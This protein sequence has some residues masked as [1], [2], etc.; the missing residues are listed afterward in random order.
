MKYT[1]TTSDACRFLDR[2]KMNKSRDCLTFFHSPPPPPYIVHRTWHP[3]AGPSHSPAA[4]SDSS[5]RLWD[6]STNRGGG[7]ESEP[8]VIKHYTGHQK[9][10]VCVALNDSNE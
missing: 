7:Q 10:I 4:S 8:E 3:L 9:A 2:F 6:L 1:H 5:A